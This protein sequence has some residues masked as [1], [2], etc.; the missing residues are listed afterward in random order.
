MRGHD[1]RGESA[2]VRALPLFF[3]PPARRIIT[4]S[5]VDGEASTD[6]APV[7]H[8]GWTPHHTVRCD[9]WKCEAASGSRLAIWALLPDNFM[10]SQNDARN[11]LIS[12][13]T[14]TWHHLE[15][16][17][18][19]SGP[20]LPASAAPNVG[21]P[22]GARSASR[23]SAALSRTT[24]S[25][26]AAKPRTDRARTPRRERKVALSM[27]GPIVSWRTPRPI[28]PRVNENISGTR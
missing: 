6:A 8:Y 10:A 25:V 22:A 27:A 18:I 26:V 19:P 23:P 5:V 13:V 7:K 1:F 12:G 2:V 3:L 20:S 24:P 11:L 16:S 17:E 14:C 4:P 15:A 28:S 21:T 9:S